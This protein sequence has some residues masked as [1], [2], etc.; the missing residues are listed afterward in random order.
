MLMLFGLVGRK[1]GRSSKVRV[2]TPCSPQPWVGVAVAEEATIELDVLLTV[3]EAVVVVAEEETVDFVALIETEATEIGVLVDVAALAVTV[4]AT[5]DVEVVE[6]VPVR[7][8][9]DITD[10]NELVGKDR[11]GVPLARVVFDVK[12]FTADAE[13]LDAD[14]EDEGAA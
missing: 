5:E 3:E 11:T 1:L 8:D 10:T 14:N 12:L 7:N 9:V 2:N 4:I 13:M 6:P